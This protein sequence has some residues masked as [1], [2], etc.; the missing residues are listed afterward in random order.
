MNDEYGP[1]YQDGYSAGK[2]AAGWWEQDN[3]GG[4]A[5]GDVKGA[6]RATLKALD[7]EAWPDFLDDLAGPL[8]NGDEE[9]E[10]GLEHG[11]QAGI[12]EACNAL[13]EE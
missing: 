4:R 13:L 3:I 7:E 9:F 5:S 2:N 6:A 11:L 1:T 10:E 12:T 8:R